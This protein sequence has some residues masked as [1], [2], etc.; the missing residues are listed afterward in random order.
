MNKKESF[1]LTQF[2]F[3]QIKRNS[4]TNSFDNYNKTRVYY[5]FQN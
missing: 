3:Y 2:F 4:Q 5:F 1:Q